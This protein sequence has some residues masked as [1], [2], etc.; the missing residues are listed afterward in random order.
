MLRSRQVVDGSRV[1]KADSDKEVVEADEPGCAA[2]SR[3]AELAG[4]LGATEKVQPRRLG[5][6]L[7]TLASCELADSL[8]LVSLIQRH[9]ML[10]VSKE[11]TD[12][13]ASVF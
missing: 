8:E 12:A 13:L 2:G 1:L 4:G 11:N 9:C 10:V 6:G 7:A 5:A 3:G